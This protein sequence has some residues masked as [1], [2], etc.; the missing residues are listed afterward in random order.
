MKFPENMPQ[1][2]I[3]AGLIPTNNRKLYQDYMQW[4]YLLAQRGVHKKHI[5]KSTF[6]CL[7]K[8]V[9]HPWQNSRLL[10][11]LQSSFIKENLSLSLLLE[12]LDG[13]EWLSKNRYPLNFS[14]SSPILL[15]IISPISRFVAALN[16]QHPPVYQPLSTLI[17][18]YLALYLINMPKLID[19]LKA[20]DISVNATELRQELTLRL[21]EAKQILP[22]IKGM[23]FKLK[24]AFYI[25][26]CQKLINQKSP[27]KINF[28]GYVNALL[29]GLWYTLTTKGKK[30]KFRKI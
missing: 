3:Y 2:D 30:I 8:A 21:N 26:L 6:N 5:A 4:I 29:A 12:P 7:Y 23:G 25:G 19:V 17:S 27:K 24:V 15:Q 20:A 10:G 1:L 16:R 9:S 18:I 13:F 28:F 14:S 11:R 22:Q